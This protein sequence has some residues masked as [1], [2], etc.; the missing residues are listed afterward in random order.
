MRSIA[1]LAVGAITGAAGVYSFRPAGVPV[2]AAFDEPA[3]GS[4]TESPADVGAGGAVGA[5]IAVLQRAAEAG[6]A[7]DLEAMLD[8]AAVAPR[9]RARDLE[10]RV[11]L[12]RLAELDPDR[13]VD[14]AQS[15]FLDTLFLVQAFTAL[16]SVDPDNAIARLRSVRPAARQRGVALGLLDVLGA[17]AS[18]VQRI[19]EGLP[20]D[21]RSS[22]ELDALLAR[23]EIDPFGVLSEVLAG[24][25]PGK[26]TNLLPRLAELAATQDPSRAV[27]LGAEIK[28]VNL[29]SS[30]EYAV[31]GAWAESDPDAVFAWLETAEPHELA[32]AAAA[33]RMLAEA[34]ADRLLAMLDSL[35]PAARTAARRAAASALA[36]RDPVAAL[37]LFEAMPM[38][39]DRETLLRTIAQSYARQDPET[40]LAWARSLVPPSPNA[41]QSVLQGIAMVDAD[42]AID[43]FIEELGAE[44][45]TESA[46]PNAAAVSLGFAM[47]LTSLAS[48]GAAVGRFT[49]KLLEL[50]NPQ[51]P[52]ILS[53]TL[54]NWA[55]RDAEAA[56]SWT[57]GNAGQLDS[58]ALRNIARSVAEASLDLAVSSLDQ[59]PSQ[60]Q[61]AWVEGLGAEMAQVD[62]DRARSFLE[63]FR[64]RPG[65]AAAL[66]TVASEMART[67]PAGAARLITGAGSPLALERS[68]TSVAR[69]W[70]SLD[71]GAAARW[72]IEDITDAEVRSTALNQVGSVWAQRDAEAAERWLFS[73]NSGP[74]RDAAADGYLAAAAQVGRFEPRL[75]EVYSSE[76][77]G[78]RGVSRAVVTMAR[79]APDRADEVMDAYLTDQALRAQTEQQ[80]AQQL[81]ASSGAVSGTL[82]VPQ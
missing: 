58:N 12:E 53:M 77:A 33:F 28:D 61:A 73:L 23:A 22:F 42:R 78:Q 81:S 60:Q 51:A 41:V 50:D 45:A 69:R 76:L 3:T 21:D 59:L 43:L 40:A 44:R 52:S 74:N 57:L 71:P 11:L 49:D 64:G 34:D 56:L 4:T 48:D 7:L 72:A 55:A 18:A 36:E 30:Y 16:A 15:S 70:A 47:L 13:A 46:A 39:Q 32:S 29:A 17:D 5:R 54:S 20:E 65:Y 75:L 62:V 8:V 63:Q 24:G 66:G 68:A 35:P 79:V 10:T 67:D 25:L 37:A 2:D 31:F 9:S 82:V 19:A 14:Y 38:G 26:R 80:I 6:D 27:A 1:L